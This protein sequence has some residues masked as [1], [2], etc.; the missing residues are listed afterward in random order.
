M[1]YPGVFF[2]YLNFLFFGLLRGVKRQKIAQNE[3]Q[4]LHL[5]CTISQE[6]YSL[7]SWVLVHLCKLIISAGV[8]IFLIFSFFGLLGQKN[9]QKNGPRWQKKI[10]LLEL[11]FQ[12]PY[13]IWLWFMVHLCKMMMSL[14][15]FSSFF[16]SFFQNITIHRM[17][18]ICGA[19]V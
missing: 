11:I 16:L 4:Q 1:I 19:Q 8:F 2:I 18:V 7:W 9:G 17:I 12:E 13:L 15:F 3:I 14:A 6:Q 10:C 5:S